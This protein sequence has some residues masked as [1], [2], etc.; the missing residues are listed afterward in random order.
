M[1]RADRQW[2]LLQ[3]LLLNSAMAWIDP[4]GKHGWAPP[5]SPVDH[6]EPICAALNLC[7]FLL[8]RE[9]AN[10][11]ELTQVCRFAEPR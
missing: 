1:C 4:D 7:R 10:G 3:P 6:I 8:I 11:T 2:Q 5:Q 9:E